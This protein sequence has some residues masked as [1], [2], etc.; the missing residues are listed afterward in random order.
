M[1]TSHVVRSTVLL[2][3]L[4][5]IGVVACADAIESAEGV[6]VDTQE[7][8]HSRRGH[9]NGSIGGGHGHRKLNVQLG[10]RPEFLVN[11]MDE[12]PLKET[13]AEC[14]EGPFGQ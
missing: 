4:S 10:P 7:Q 8:A 11:D 9:W 13:L 3:A 6:A 5:T 12:G 14:S 2:T 1:Q